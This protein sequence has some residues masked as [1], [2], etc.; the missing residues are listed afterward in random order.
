[1]GSVHAQQQ[2][3]LDGRASRGG[4]KDREDRGVH[5]RD[6]GAGVGADAEDFGMALSIAVNARARAPGHSCEMRGRGAYR[7][8]D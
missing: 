4:G 5:G 2:R 1:V 6:R 8:R 7:P 3:C